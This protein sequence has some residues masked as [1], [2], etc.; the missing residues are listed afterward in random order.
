MDAT[1]VTAG[2]LVANGN[3]SEARADG[4][5]LLA[6]AGRHTFEVRSTMSSGPPRNRDA[7]L[8]HYASMVVRNLLGRVEGKREG[9]R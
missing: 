5:D 7:M 1:G 3:F 2:D 6:I 9:G 8:G 4:G